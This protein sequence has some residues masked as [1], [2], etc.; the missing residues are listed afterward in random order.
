MV[1]NPP[2]AQAVEKFRYALEG[3]LKADARFASFHRH[4]RPDGSTL[5]TRWT[6]AANPQVWFEIAVRPLIPQ[7]RVGILTDDRWKS[8]DLEGKI[9]ESGDSMSEFVEMG[10]H[11]AGLEWLEPT[12]EH[13]REEMKFFYFATA[14]ELKDIAE[15]ASADVRKKAEQMLDGYHHAFGPFLK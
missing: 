2:Q 4:D 7:V 15:L 5:A 8:E 9:E 13:Y 1:I 6:S 10:F 14:F 3:E 12:V 11:E